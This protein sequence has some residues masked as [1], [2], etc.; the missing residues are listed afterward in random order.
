M[1]QTLLNLLLKRKMSFK[2]KRLKLIGK[3]IVETKDYKELVQLCN[4]YNK[5]SGKKYDYESSFKFLNDSL[6]PINDTH[7]KNKLE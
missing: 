2:Q 5:I 6:N 7:K 3:K 1:L 4:Q